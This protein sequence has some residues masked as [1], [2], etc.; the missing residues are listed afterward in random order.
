M[1]PT[2]RYSVNI[3]QGRVLY[4]TRSGGYCMTYDT[5]HQDEVKFIHTSSTPKDEILLNVNWMN[6]PNKII[7]LKNIYTDHTQS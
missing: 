7:W 2:T 3:L 1:H 4:I 6:L 5:I